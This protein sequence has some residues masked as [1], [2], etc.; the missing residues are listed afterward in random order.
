[1]KNK[2]RGAARGRRLGFEMLERR[3]VM[4]GNV[5][6]ALTGGSAILRG[7]GAANEITIT[8]TGPHTL[9]IAGVGTKINGKTGPVTLTGYTKDLTLNMNGGNDVV[10]IHGTDDLFRVLGDLKIGTQDGND[11]IHLEDLAVAGKLTISTGAGKDWFAAGMGALEAG[12][13]VAKNVSIATGSDSDRA[14]LDHA[15]LPATVAFDL[16]T[17][18]DHLSLADCGLGKTTAT[19][20]S[21]TDDLQVAGTLFAK[22]TIRSFELLGSMPDPVAGQLAPLSVAA[23]AESPPVS[24][25]TI[26]PLITQNLTLFVAPGGSDSTGDGSITRPWSSVQRALNYLSEKS[27][28]SS[29][30]VLISLANGTYTFTSALTIQHAAGAN[31]HIV[32]NP[33]AEG[34][35]IL[36]FTGGTDGIFVTDGHALGYLDGVTVRG[37]WAGSGNAGLSTSAIRASRNASIALGDHVTVEKFYYGIQADLGGSV[38]ADSIVVNSA[39][40]GGLFAY[41]GGVIDS[42]GA[43]IRNVGDATRLLGGGVIA[44]I[45]GTVR[46]NALTVTACLQAGIQALGGNV[47]SDSFLTSGNQ[48]YGIYIDRNGVVDGDGASSASNNLGDGIH[49]ES[50]GVLRTYGV[51]TVNNNGGHGLYVSQGHVT[52]ARNSHIDGNKFSGVYATAGSQVIVGT[53]STLNANKAHGVDAFAMSYVEVVSCSV[54]SNLAKGLMASFGSFVN[55]VGASVTR[56]GANYGLAVDVLSTD[57]SL[58]KTK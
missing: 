11:Q 49:I 8:Q 14:T 40:D 18:N 50:G 5:T 29:A 48:G 36:N 21:G 22:Q 43:I 56:N 46:A 31:I 30:S 12:V 45:G 39:G 44:E 26:G 58:I 57:G 33:T 13:R 15:Q 4:A 34:L 24:P 35:V 37:L 6:A 55:A 51:L 53:G 47:R 16:G 17:G 38:E 7:D 19:G 27:I 1:M 41:N 28:S 23:G 52:L 32:G 3:E 42:T 20:G 10:R 9:T 54:T 2:G 25:S